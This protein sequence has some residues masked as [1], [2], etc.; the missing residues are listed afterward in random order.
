MNQKVKFDQETAFNNILGINNKNIIKEKKSKKKKV[1]LNLYENIY[2]DVQKIAYVERKSVSEI[3]GEL[4]NDFVEKN[5]DLLI[6][7]QKIKNK[8]E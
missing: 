7:Y 8:K 2:C 4:I 6:E 3:I 5:Q 1:T